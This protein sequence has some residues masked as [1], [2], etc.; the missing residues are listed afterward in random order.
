MQALYTIE[1]S[2]QPPRARILEDWFE[3]FGFQLL[4]SG[5]DLKAVFE[6]W[7]LIAI[8]PTFRM[9]IRIDSVWAFLNI[10]NDECAAGCRHTFD[11]HP[12]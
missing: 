3:S 8:N 11:G 4:L 7:D 6:A 12:S 10:S 1:K 5:L 2:A 9:I